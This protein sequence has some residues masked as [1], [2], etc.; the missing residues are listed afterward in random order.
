MTAYPH[1]RNPI[2]EKIAAAYGSYS[3]L[4]R[5]LGVTRQSVWAWKEVPLHHV[6][7]IAAEKNFKL[8]ELRPDI[9]DAPGN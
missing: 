8:H 3:E 4:A 1:G 2:I 9:Y 7:R 5:V 6:R